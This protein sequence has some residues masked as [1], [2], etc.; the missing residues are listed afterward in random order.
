MWWEGQHVLSHGTNFGAGVA[1]LFSSGLGVTVVSTTEIGCFF[2]VYAPNEGTERIAV[3]DQLKE[4]LRQCD[5]E[6]CMVL[7]GDWN[8]TVDF[9][10]DRTAERLSRPLNR[11][12]NLLN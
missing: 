2:Y 7:G 10:V 4:T 11:T 3:F 8:C 6:G 9:T 5:Q 1:I 12:S